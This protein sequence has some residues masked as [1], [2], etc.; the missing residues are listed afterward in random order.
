MSELNKPN[1]TAK[2]NSSNGTTKHADYGERMNERILRYE[3]KIKKMDDVI[4]IASDS[5][6]K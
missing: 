4:K 6:E 2:T 1:K 3:T 5:K